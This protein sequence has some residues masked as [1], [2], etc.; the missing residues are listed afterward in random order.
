MAGAGK[1]WLPSHT[2]VSALKMGWRVPKVVLAR[3]RQLHLLASEPGLFKSFNDPMNPA[4]ASLPVRLRLAAGQACLDMFPPAALETQLW[5]PFLQEAFPSAQP[6]TPSLR[7][8]SSGHPH[9]PCNISVNNCFH[10]SLLTG[11]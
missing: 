10:F 5:H 11:L 9:T 8:P 3:R 2:P 7:C 4:F 1:T 6:N